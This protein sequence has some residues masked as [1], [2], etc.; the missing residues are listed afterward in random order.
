M[1]SFG[2]RTDNCVGHYGKLKNTFRLIKGEKTNKL[3]IS[4]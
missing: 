3:G 1:S 4:P 2:D